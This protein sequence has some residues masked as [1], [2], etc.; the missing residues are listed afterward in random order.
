MIKVKSDSYKLFCVSYQEREVHTERV[1]NTVDACESFS[2]GTVGEIFN[3][4]RRK[5]GLTSCIM[6]V[7]LPFEVIIKSHTDLIPKRL[8]MP[9]LFNENDIYT[10]LKK[11]HDFEI[12]LL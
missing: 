9:L 2:I 10:C 8:R 1:P 12:D 4:T 6:L 11:Y 3:V 7:E 5:L